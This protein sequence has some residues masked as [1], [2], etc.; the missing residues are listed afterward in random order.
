MAEIPRNM[1]PLRLNPQ[2]L[3]DIFA[4][5]GGDIKFHALY[6]SLYTSREAAITDLCN[7]AVVGDTNKI[8]TTIGEIRAYTSI[9]SMAGDA[10]GRAPKS[11]TE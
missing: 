3:N 4:Q 1:A 5:M 11:D 8:C 2:Q 7:D 10:R 9:L 6:D